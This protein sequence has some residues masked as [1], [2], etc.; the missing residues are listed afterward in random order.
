MKFKNIAAIAALTLATT[1]SPVAT[2]AS[3]DGYVAPVTS[4]KPCMYRLPTAGLMRVVNL[5]H[6]L[7]MSIHDDGDNVYLLRLWM[8]LRYTSEMPKITSKDPAVLERIMQ[9]IT[10]AANAC[11]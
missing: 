11:K 1:I 7:H 10:D 4:T 6:L 8:P 2:A 5:K 9:Q 3:S